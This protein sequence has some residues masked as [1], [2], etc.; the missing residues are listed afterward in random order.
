[1]DVC[2][3]ILFVAAFVMKVI[4]PELCRIVVLALVAHLHR[5]QNPCFKSY[6]GIDHI[7]DM[8]FA[9]IMTNLVTHFLL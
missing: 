9:P 8:K 7:Q 5:H 3:F 6:S 4:R 1:M 2:V